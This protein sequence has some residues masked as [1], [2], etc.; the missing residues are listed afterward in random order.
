M[1]FIKKMSLR[2]GEER[3]KGFSDPVKKAEDWS[4]WVLFAAGIAMGILV[5]LKIS[6]KI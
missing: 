2:W 1:K 3:I 5:I 4:W 6:G